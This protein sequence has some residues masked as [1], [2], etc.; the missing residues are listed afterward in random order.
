MAL[1]VFHAH[2]LDTLVVFLFFRKFLMHTDVFC[3][4]FVK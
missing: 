4:C 2:T 3:H 1:E